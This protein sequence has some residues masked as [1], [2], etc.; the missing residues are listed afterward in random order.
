MEHSAVEELVVTPPDVLCL[1]GRWPGFL[2]PDRLLVHAA[3]GNLCQPQGISVGHIS[4]CIVQV[5]S[6]RVSQRVLL[7]VQ[8]A[9]V[10]GAEVTTMPPQCLP[11]AH[12]GQ[13]KKGIDGY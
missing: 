10:G 2:S 8:L 4:R 6:P 9:Y 12:S 7:Q 3:D 11:V 1:G 13:T 5:L